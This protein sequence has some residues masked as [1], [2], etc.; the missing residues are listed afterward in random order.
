MGYQGHAAIAHSRD[1][2]SDEV[3]KRFDSF[4]VRASGDGR[5]SLCSGMFGCVS[6]QLGNS[7]RLLPVW[8][9]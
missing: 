7:R 8:G 6:N 9:S 4:Q 3:A 5:N 2:Q 1:S